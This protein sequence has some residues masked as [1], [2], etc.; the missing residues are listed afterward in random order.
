M[1]EKNAGL[2]VAHSHRLEDLTDLVVR[3][4]RIAPLNPLESECILV[5][6][7]GI[8]Q[9]LK[10]HLA[11]ATGIA[12]MLDVTLPARFQWRA[13]RAVL[14]DSLPKHSPFDKDRLTWRLMRLLPSLVEQPEFASL[15]RYIADD[16]Q[17]RKLYQ[18]CERL[19]DLF[20]Q[21]QI[22]RADWLADWAQG[23]AVKAS[24]EQA[25]QP[26]LW[27]A[28]LND[29]GTTTLPD[30]AELHQRFIAKAQQLSPQTRPT[31]LPPRII[32][33]GISS[34]PK[35]M[36]EVLHALSS[37]C[38]VVLCVHNPCRHYWA[39]SVDGSQV[40]REWRRKR[41]QR[42]PGQAEL[43]IDNLHTETH[44]LLASWGKQG[45]DY[46]AMLDQFDAT[47]EQAE[48]YPQLRFDLFD[49]APG[50]IN[51]RLQQLQDDILDLRSPIEAKPLWQQLPLD[52]SI[53]LVSC[54]SPQREVEVLH[55]QLLHLF[56]T[57]PELKPSDLIVMVP[58]IDTY[59]PH[60]QAVFGRYSKDD[61]RA[62]PFTLSDQG[63]RHRQP[64]VVALEYVLS[65]AAH[66]ATASELLDLL[67]VP[68]L[69]QRFG[70]TDAD[71]EQLQMW[72]QAAGVRWALHEQHRE[73]LGLPAAAGRNSWAFGLRRML[74]GYA[75]GEPEPFDATW[76]GD[77]PY[78]EVGGLGANAAGALQQLLQVLDDAF[79]LG[80]QEQPPQVWTAQ[81]QEL[82][83]RLFAA[84]D[85]HDELLLDKLE[86]QLHA[87]L[88][89][90]QAGAFNEPVALS[91]VTESWLSRVDEQQLNQ[92]FLAGSLNFATLMPMRAIP[93]KGVF[94]L[95]MND[96]VYP[97]QRKPFDFDLM[98]ND[99]RPGDRSRREDDRYLFLE[100]LLSA[101]RW[102]SI[103]WCGR[104][105][106]DNTEQPP[107]VLVSQLRD[108]LAQLGHEQE[109]E[110]HHM[111]AFHQAYFRRAES[112]A[113]GY[114]T[115]AH[116]WQS[117][118]QQQ[119]A[120]AAEL[121]PLPPMQL[122]GEW[123]LRQ[124][125]QF[126]QEPARWFLTQRLQSYLPETRIENHDHELF[127]LDGLTRWQLLDRM[128][129]PLQEAL[130]QQTPAEQWHQWLTRYVMHL[131]AAGEL[132]VGAAGQPQVTTLTQAGE[133]LWQQ[134][135]ALVQD[136]PQV[137]PRLTVSRSEPV[138]LVETF[139]GIRCNAAG[140][141][142]RWVVSASRIVERNGTPRYAKLL[143]QW[144]EHLL[145]NTHTPHRTFVVSV[146]TTLV[147]EALPTD[148]AEQL[149]QTI[150]YWAQ[151]GLQQPLP[152]QCEL[153]FSGWQDALKA[154]GVDAVR[155]QQGHFLNTA[156]EETY[157]QDRYKGAVALRK[158]ARYLRRFYPDF[159][160]LCTHAELA[161]EAALALYLPLVSYVVKGNG[162]NA[163]D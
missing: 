133:S 150:L 40:V 21:Y 139:T 71:L 49:A 158:R 34:L 78:P 22:Y 110:Q 10:R 9:W 7:N 107:S 52:D 154:G 13:Y 142:A 155:Q 153:V 73:Q 74:L 152:L 58:D 112:S 41:Q 117:L 96:G 45:G 105:I 126:L 23:G 75:I 8:A 109:P 4:T 68:A 116:E 27:R 141:R 63:T 161:H 50:A 106:R 18:L 134:A 83:Q 62:I 85:E 135:E 44:P 129:L 17:Q 24:G 61:P 148:L 103:S 101:R 119:P 26:V 43:S 1:S 53:R 128:Q 151:R 88:E 122:E 124:L 160:S 28:V 143:G 20:D 163:D 95:G 25:W 144:L 6:S 149:M 70:L 56:R 46:I 84:H 140:E 123:T 51:T 91:V 72:L 94:L 98:A 159:A 114:F 146:E 30:R 97:R 42:K 77:V 47:E 108:H 31:A 36:V 136:Y 132:S 14:G 5:Q 99:V 3:F 64:L 12:A 87:W 19:A 115:F 57:E 38:Q 67:Q 60:I 130:T 48:R 93:F 86:R 131:Q 54:H 89:T 127:T 111:Q 15:A 138:P 59:A 2:I 37:C 147:L 121:T 125:G 69:Q 145:L 118:H 66:R 33:F 29:V 32:V 100:A 104:S 156:A 120:G 65:I 76:G 79:A 92:R 137:C 157:M 82:M 80:V 113:R 35:Q 162:G 16:R 55:D 39:D 81:L 11:E 102:F 90:T